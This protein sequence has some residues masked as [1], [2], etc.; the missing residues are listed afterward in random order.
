MRDEHIPSIILQ[1][2]AKSDPSSNTAV[3]KIV[4]LFGENGFGLIFIFFSLP[5]ALPIPYPPG[6]TIVFAI[7]LVVGGIQMFLGYKRV[8][9]P[10]FIESY[11][12]KNSMLIKI[13]E[14]SVNTLVKIENYLSTRLEFMNSNFFE[15]LIALSAISCGV[16]IA[17]PVPFTH[18]LPAWGLLITSL[19]MIKKDGI[20]ILI[21]FAI[22]IAGIIVAYILTK[23]TWYVVKQLIYKVFQLK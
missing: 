21:G 1:N 5:L 18:S 23:S 14:R 19:G 11:K 10:S 20:V 4:E 7:P 13:S 9:L 2:L 16:I 3:G 8:K 12:V 6:F 22:S 15:K 17:L